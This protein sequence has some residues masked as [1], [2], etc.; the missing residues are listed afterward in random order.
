MDHHCPWVNNCVGYYNYRYFVLFLI[1]LWVACAYGLCILF[2]PFMSLVYGGGR[3]PHMPVI[4]GSLASER[5]A[6]V[7]TFV[8]A[9]SVG[10]ALSGLL[11]WHVFLI[12][13]GQTTIEFYINRACREKARQRGV[14]YT[15]PHNLGCIR[16]WQ[17]VF[18][19][20]LPW[21]RT[22]LPSTR[23]PPQM[24]VIMPRDEEEEGKE[25]EEGRRRGRDGHRGQQQSEEEGRG[26]LMV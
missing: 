14:L 20:T 8:L 17:Q 22:F 6:I 19:F 16:N 25:E 18:G 24:T 9:L 13:S 21:Y 5:S 10:I 7:F 3:G 1:Y 23:L 4:I 2:R 15:N 26:L 12:S 11:G